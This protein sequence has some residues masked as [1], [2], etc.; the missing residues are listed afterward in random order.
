MASFNRGYFFSA[1]RNSFVCTHRRAP[2]APPG[3]EVQH[4]VNITY[5]S[6]SGVARLIENPAHDDGVVR[7]IE[8]AEH[9]SRPLAGSSPAAAA[10]QAVEVLLVEP[11]ED[12]LQIVIPSLAVRRESSARGSAAPGG[13]W[14]RISRGSNTA[15]SDE[16]SCALSACVSL[17][18][19]DVGQRFAH[20]RRRGVQNVGNAHVD[21]P[22]SRR[23]K[24]SA[25]ANLQNSTLSAAPAF[26]AAIHEYT[27][28]RSPPAFRTSSALAKP[29]GTALPVCISSE[30]PIKE[31]TLNLPEPKSP[32][33]D[34]TPRPAF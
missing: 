21:Q 2:R 26:A 24:L 22:F 23:M 19:Q 17:A 14:R 1:F 8:M 32:P 31:I 12:L 16:C 9:V 29:G 34:A 3:C 11:L 6:A 20:R 10:Q 25:L 13:I 4:F 18:E 28:V 30:L 7:R 33:W 5:S 15:G 27:A